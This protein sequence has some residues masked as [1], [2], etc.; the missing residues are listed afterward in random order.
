MEGKGQPNQPHL[1]RSDPFIDGITSRDGSGNLVPILAREPKGVGVEH[2]DVEPA[3]REHDSE[4]APP[5]R[6]FVEQFRRLPPNL[7]EFPITEG[8]ALVTG[9]FRGDVA[10]DWTVDILGIQ[11][12]RQL[13]PAEDPAPPSLRVI[14][15]RLPC[16]VQRCV[17]V[18]VVVD[19]LRKVPKEIRSEVAHLLDV[20]DDERHIL[21][22][23]KSPGVDSRVPSEDQG[24][25]TASG[26][27]GHPRGGGFVIHPSGVE[28]PPLLQRRRSE[29]SRQLVSGAD[30][31]GTS[32]GEV[33]CSS[34]VP[35]GTHGRSSGFHA[36][37]DR[38]SSASSLAMSADP[39]SKSKTSAF[40]RIRSGRTDFGIS[41][42]P[43]WSPH[44]MRT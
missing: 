34:L 2:M 30:H 21:Q 39:I 24:E 26:G 33:K 6:Q 25:D 3:A 43:C 14:D 22:M 17:H 1:A 20:V 8:Q 10:V 36:R 32:D 13:L 44:R 12:E 29:V 28:T 31:G 38:S 27:T 23:P 41:T 9:H 16:L 15:S 7:L 40:S 5:T 18:P 4:A 11:V 35:D 19:A 37:W 42:R